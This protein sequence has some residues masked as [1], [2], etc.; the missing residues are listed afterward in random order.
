MTL[1]DNICKICGE[2]FEDS[3]SLC[4]HL[5]KHSIYQRD[6]FEKYFPKIC[7]YS[8]LKIQ[9]KNFDQYISS[10]F[11][12]DIY[13]KKYFEENINSSGAKD[14]AKEMLLNRI[15]QKN[16]KECPT[17]LELKSLN[18][19]SID[20]FTNLFG[21]YGGICKEIGI[22]MLLKKRMPK[23][24]NE[25]IPD[26]PI[27]IDTREQKPLSFKNSMVSKVDVGDYT[28]PRQHFTN[29]FVDRKSLGDFEGTFSSGVNRF[30]RELQRCRTLGCFLYIVVE[31]KFESIK[32]KSFSKVKRPSPEYIF[33]N[34]REIQHEFSDCCQFV[35]S[36]SRKNS[37]ILIPRLLFLGKE[38][39]NV[40]IQ[41]YLEKGY[42]DELD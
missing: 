11:F 14:L 10:F 41:Y 42:I 13:V 9:Y 36:G 25:S 26:V 6:Y 8:K 20:V 2:Q 5:K 1:F 4:S 22:E 23:E 35:F 17:Y 33:H 39:W 24:I 15:R 31:S 3:K 37:E 18:M 38:L 12:C 7:P 32:E 27:L 40:D 21:S 19:P 34:V 29:T 28:F 16:L 30:K